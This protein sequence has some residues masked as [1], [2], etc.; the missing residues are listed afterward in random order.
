MEITLGENSPMSWRTK[1]AKKTFNPKYNDSFVIPVRNSRLK[2]KIRAMDKFAQKSKEHLGEFSV[3]LD[4]LV[5]N[6]E[7]FYRMRFQ[8]VESGSLKFSMTAIGYGHQGTPSNRFHIFLRLF[9]SLINKNKN[10]TTLDEKSCL[11]Y[12][13]LNVDPKRDGKGII[14]QLVQ[15][16][17]SFCLF[18]SVFPFFSPSS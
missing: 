6:Q 11:N 17:R 12:A 14:Y 18:F 5:E 2:L 4:E 3:K 15:A 13:L 1:T 16:G 9:V 7:K 10:K 8:G